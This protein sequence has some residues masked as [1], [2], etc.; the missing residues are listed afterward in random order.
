MAD[1]KKE[2][3]KASF[4]AVKA[5]KCAALITHSTLEGREGEKLQR[6]A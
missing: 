3:K 1:N 4:M 2:F 5:E 6:E